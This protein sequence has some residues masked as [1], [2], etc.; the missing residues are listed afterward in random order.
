MLTSVVWC[1]AIRERS[2][3][4]P[5]L[6]SP[7]DRPAYSRSDGPSGVSE[8]ECTIGA[9]TGNRVRCM[10]C[11]MDT[12]DT[13]TPSKEH[14]LSKPVAKAFG[15]DR[16]SPVL[17]TG[18]DLADQRWARL[19]GIQYCCVCT[20]CNNG[21][22][23]RMEGRMAEVA[24]WLAGDQ[25]VPLGQDLSI[26]LRKWAVKSHLLLHFIDGNTNR[27]DDD[28]FAGDYVIPPFTPARQ[29]YENDD[30]VLAMAVGIAKSGART[31]FAWS[32][33]FATATPSEPP[34]LVRFAPATV[35]TVGDL[36][37]WVVTPQKPADVSVPS[38]VLDC[39]AAVRPRD[40]AHFGHPLDV[41][42]V[43]VDFH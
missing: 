39:S 23:N 27:W 31:D 18:S 36:M 33:G 14:L 8:G 2:C 43:I 3:E 13:I 25:N 1:R 16:D 32:F 15:I 21:W 40:L 35:L 19:N 30:A 34:G 11:Y 29:M 9:V 20:D 24:A 6:G 7:G 41:T 38:G 37:L 17:R 10:F 12:V 28:T 26:L 42:D 5:R 4:R 22:M